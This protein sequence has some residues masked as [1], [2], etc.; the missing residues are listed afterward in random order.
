MTIRTTKTT[1]VFHDSFL[2]PYF[3]HALPAG[4][5]EVVT[6]EEQLEGISFLAYRRLQTYIYRRSPPPKTGLAPTYVVDPNDLEE[7]FL[8]DGNGDQAPVTVDWST[9]QALEALPAEFDRASDDG[10]FIGSE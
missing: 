7:A 6:E 9:G 10:M 3:D 8:R 2:M 1:M 4:T 5:Y